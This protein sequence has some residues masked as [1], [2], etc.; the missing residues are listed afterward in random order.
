MA[1]VSPVTIRTNPQVPSRGPAIDSPGRGMEENGALDRIRTCDL[2]LRRR[3]LYPAELP[4]QE[5]VAAPQG[6]HPWYVFPAPPSLAGRSP[7]AFVRQSRQVPEAGWHGIV[8]D[9]A[10]RLESVVVV[11][12][13]LPVHRGKNLWLNGKIQNKQRITGFAVMSPGEIPVFGGTNRCSPGH[14]S[15]TSFPPPLGWTRRVRVSFCP[16]AL[17]RRSSGVRIWGHGRSPDWHNRQRDRYR[18]WTP[19]LC[20]RSSASPR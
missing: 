8:A 17:Q 6:T 14:S 13:N 11:S 7:A 2:P 5:I 1:S 10:G 19:L 3:M 18:C 4:G 20:C 12:M 9:P 16:Q 15:N